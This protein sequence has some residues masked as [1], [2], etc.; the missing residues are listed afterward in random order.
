MN[1]RLFAT[2]LSAFL[3][4]GEEATSGSPAKRYSVGS[5]QRTPWLGAVLN[6][7][8]LSRIAS[9]V[10]VVCEEISRVDHADETARRFIGPVGTANSNRHLKAATNARI[11]AAEEAAIV[12]I[13]ASRDIEEAVHK[14]CKITAEA[15]GHLNDEWGQHPA[16]YPSTQLDAKETS[17]FADLYATATDELID[18]LVAVR[19]ASKSIV[20]QNFI[21]DRRLEI[22]SHAF[23]RNPRVLQRARRDLG[24]LPP[25]EPKK[26]ATD[27]LSYLIGAAFGRW[28]LRIA[29][30][31]SLAPEMPGLFSP[32]PLCPPGMLLGSDG[33][34]AT[35]A[36]VTYPIELP[37]MRLLIDEPGHRWD[38]EGALQRSAAALFDD[39]STIVE[40]LLEALGH[41]TIRDYLRKQFFKDHLSRYSK[42]RRKAPIYWPLTVPSKNWGIWVYVPMLSRETLYGVASEAGRRER[43]AGEAIARLQRDQSEGGAGRP[44]R[45]VAAELDAEER[46]AEELRKFRGEAERIAGL[47]WQPDLDDGSILCAAPLAELFTSWPDAKTARTELR[48]GEHQWATVAA[49]ATQL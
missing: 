3:A 16:D 42:S 43:L 35:D 14:A 4:A 45:K 23:A 27:L 17:D 6:D 29:R 10:S 39:S 21:A 26:S 19:G 28:D 24:L 8:G 36:P 30:N 9:Q 5:I 37:P 40:E 11:E 34:P 7:D 44:V 33:M 2:L 12:A 1:T 32:V 20:L 22:L 38:I 48:R 46:L 31:P 47:G 13:E 49:W 15:I 41:K 18:R 25:E